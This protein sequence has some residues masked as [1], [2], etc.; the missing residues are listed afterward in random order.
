MD[1]ATLRTKGLIGPLNSPQARTTAFPYE[2]GRR[3]LHEVVE[4]AY[5][6]IA[7]VTGFA[8]SAA[9]PAH[10]GALLWITQTIRRR[11][12]GGLHE[13]A[14][15]EMAHK[16]TRRLCLVVKH[17]RDALWATEEAVVSGAVNHIIAEVDTVDFTATRRLAL[18]SGRHGVPVTLILPDG[19][20]GATA[21]ATRWR[22]AARP[23]APNPYDPKAPGRAR[24]R[25]NLERCRLNPSAAGRTFDLEWNDETLSLSVVSGMVA[26]PAA[27]CTTPPHNLPQRKAG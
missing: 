14:L 4:Q 16:K 26:G 9:R 20:E 13:L 1:L 15:R 22:I 11:D 19:H 18:A 8:L 10:P 27:P 25:A 3:G 5:G 17:A 2:L 24:W 12:V 6:D 7:A 21:A 23:S